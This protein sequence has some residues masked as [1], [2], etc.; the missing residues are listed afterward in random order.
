MADKTVLVTDYTWASTEPEARVLEK[1]GAA[2]AHFQDGC[3]R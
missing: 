2:L 1:V 3:G